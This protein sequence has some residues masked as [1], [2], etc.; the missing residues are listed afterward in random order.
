MS[1]WSVPRL[2]EDKT[3]VVM[4]S[5]PSLNKEDADAVKHLPR[6]VTNGTFR[7]AR[8]AEVIYAGDVFFWQH[9]DYRDVFDCPGFK[10]GI[11]SV[12]GSHPCTPEPVLILKKGGRLGLSDNPASLQTGGNSGY[13]AINL[14]ALFGAK[15]ILVLGLDMT[16]GHWHGK[17]PAGL[18]NPGKDTFKRW[19][20]LFKTLAPALTERGIEVINCSPISALEVFPKKALRDCL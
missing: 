15:R 20:R 5:G 9:K 17:H 6:V 11:E 13:A 7:M 19:I 14:A 4:A 12:P 18:S 3:A 1:Y 10:V 2:W 16:G 8:D